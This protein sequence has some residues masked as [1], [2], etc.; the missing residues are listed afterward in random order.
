MGESRISIFTVP[1]SRCANPT[2]LCPFDH[3]LSEEGYIATQFT[4]AKAIHAMS[5]NVI[6]LHDPHRI[7]FASFD[8]VVKQRMHERNFFSSSVFILTLT[9]IAACYQFFLSLWMAFLAMVLTLEK[10][11]KQRS[12]DF[13]F[14]S[15]FFAS[16]SFLD[17]KSFFFLHSKTMSREGF[18]FSIPTGSGEWRNQ[19]MIVR[20]MRAGKLSFADSFWVTAESSKPLSRGEWFNK[21]FVIA[22]TLVRRLVSPSIS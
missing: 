16:L 20:Q 5:E 21:S 3:A 14:L 6:Q 17:G 2:F 9:H 1:I 7:G 18:I 10:Q 22:P 11:R 4:H 15:F 12:V 13:F 19:A 8:L